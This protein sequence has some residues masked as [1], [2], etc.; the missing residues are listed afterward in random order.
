MTTPQ[1]IPKAPQPASR[2]VLVVDDYDDSADVV[3]KILELRG[4]EV[5]TAKSGSEAI[6]KAERFQPDLMLLDISMP[7]M[8][9]YDVCLHVKRQPWGKGIT[10]AAMTGCYGDEHK[11]LAIEAG[12]DYYLIKPINTE[13]IDRLLAGTRKGEQ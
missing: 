12:F 2:R 10:I 13:A 5:Q 4:N 11:K 3:A 1:Q 9:G 7:L 6:A 8:D